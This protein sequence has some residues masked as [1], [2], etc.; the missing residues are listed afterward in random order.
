M[1]GIQAGN[2]IHKNS[3]QSDKIFVWGFD[4]RLYVYAK[5]DPAT[6]YS[7]CCYITGLIP[8]VNAYREINTD[9]WIVPGSMDILLYELR[10]NKPIFIIDTSPGNIA[11]FGKY[12]IK[13]FPE[14]HKFVN[15]YYSLKKE[16]KN[17]NGQTFL[18]IYFYENQ[19]I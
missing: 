1:I 5:R 2:Y 15:Q 16:F 18:N 3:K 7:D 11:G 6:R 9:K 10:K 19:G 17:I 13:R 8:W 14:L 12:P 4:P